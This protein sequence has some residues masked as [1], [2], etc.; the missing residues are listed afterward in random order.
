[1]SQIRDDLTECYGDELLFL[2]PGIQFDSCIVGVA[3]RCGMNDCVVYQTDKV[4]NSLVQAGMTHDDAQEH[5]DFNIIGAYVGPA[6][7]LFMD[8]IEPEAI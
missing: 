2:D 1:M 6:T 7:P 4:L 5:F 3:T 8:S